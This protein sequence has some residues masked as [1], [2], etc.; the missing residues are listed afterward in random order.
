MAEAVRA[1]G[2]VALARGYEYYLRRLTARQRAAVEAV[3]GPVMV[4]AGPGTGKTE[5]LTMRIATILRMTQADPGN[6]L[7]LTFT[8]S[9]AAA[10]R[11]RLFE[12][13]GEAAY[14][15]RMTTFHAFCR[16]VIAEHPDAFP[17][18][19]AAV[20]SGAERVELFRS[21]LDELPGTNRLKPFGRPYTLVGDLIRAVQQ[22]KKEGVTPT[23]L[24]ALVRCNQAIGRQL[25]QTLAPFFSLPPGKR[26]A[27]VCT[28]AARDVRA[29]VD[30][31][32]GGEA[33][34]PVMAAIIERY[35]QEAEQARD[36]R[37]A[38]KARTQFKRELKRIVDRVLVHGPRW[39]ALA[40]VY[41]RYQD[42]LRERDR[43]DFEDML[44]LV[45]E[46]LCQDE[47]LMAR[48][49]ERWHYILVDEYQDTNGA[50]NEL[51]MGLG[52]FY[53]NPN[54][55]VVGDDQ[56]SIFRFQG[57]SL[58]NLLTFYERYRRWVRV[59]PLTDNWRSQRTILDAARA[60]IVRNTAALDELGVD[61][62]LQAQRAGAR[63]KLERR[64]FTS[65]DAEDYWVAS[66]IQ[67]LLAM[68][69][70]A[71]EI[72]VLYRY[73]RDADSLSDFLRRLNVPMHMTA[74]EDV[75]A[76]RRVQQLLVLLQAVAD[77]RDETLA[78][79][80]FYDFLKLSA[81]DALK[82]VYAAARSRR[83]VL[84]VLGSAAQLRAA[85]VA[86]LEPFAALARHLARWRKTAANLTL[87]QLF[88]TVLQESGLLTRLT[89]DSGHVTELHCLS[90]L[91]NELKRLAASD[92]ELTVR[93]FTERMRLLREH[94][95]PLMAEPWQ[96]RTEAVQLLTAHKAKGLE[97][98]HVFI[99]RL[100]DRHWGNVRER[101]RL[102]L[103]LGIVRHDPLAGTDNNEE[104]R[105]LFYVALTRAKDRVYLSYARHAGGERAR[106]ASLFWHELP[107]ACVADVA[108]EETEAFV[109]RRLAVL[110]LAQPAGLPADIREWLK[111][112]LKTYVLSVTHLNNYLTCP[113]LFLWRNV[114]LVPS[115][116]TR[117][118]AFGTA[119]H[120]SLR[121]LFAAARSGGK[122]PGSDWLLARWQYH[123]QREVLST[124]DY[125]DALTVGQKVLR[126]YRGRYRRTWVLN[127]LTEYSFRSHGV[128]IGPARVT[129][130]LDKVE[131]VDTRRRLAN[132][133]D[134]KTG[135]P[136]YARAHLKEEGQYRRQ[137]V[138]YQLLCDTSRRFPYRMVSGEIDFVQ[139]SARS[140]KFVKQRIEISRDD[141]MALAEV[142]AQVWEDITSLT[143]LERP[144][145]GECVYCREG[146]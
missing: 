140:G 15:V 74:G 103:P 117:A 95:V 60:V 116:K 125:H 32:A 27:A 96:T 106:A 2:R 66:R 72:A 42:Q 146:R 59:L 58:E 144:G 84:A 30:S 54:I 118:L 56:Q 139:P 138:F 114:V 87:P 64:I 25:G 48:L 50:Q 119:V 23:R 143:F 105:R 127:T 36:G 9:V 19:G 7:C 132:V 110:R 11:D 37:T 62:V 46:R 98:T 24:R 94:G 67:E 115:A 81:L 61:R 21:L 65:G 130:T 1:R 20:L 90:T 99:I 51:L 126:A 38:G 78:D 18:A 16:E 13:I 52:S 141:T 129:G 71:R 121:D 8:D 17:A 92:H 41:A 120:S 111:E 123:L 29:I 10:M 112:R 93:Q 79:V 134:Y 97:F 85:G 80:L 12:I 22:L 86:R 5:V 31:V 57:A 75:L 49:Q 104:E 45:V 68:G 108:A 76:D 55:F 135:N 124:A 137:L 136:D 70:P 131:I 101:S 40:R 47:G 109:Q 43:I 100:T 82:I 89:G 26:T 39:R 33:L 4:L 3:E 53:P 69:V 73:N 88:D 128:R 6:I 145:C 77:P 133:V 63:V 102:P 83:G 142:I 91:F 35:R 107:A 14:G 28:A 122:L 44:L 113:R 34:A